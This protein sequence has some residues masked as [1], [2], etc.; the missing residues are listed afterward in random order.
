MSLSRLKMPSINASI[1]INE[2]STSISNAIN[3]E[4]NIASPIIPEQFP[5]TVFTSV[6]LLF[7]I[8][9]TIFA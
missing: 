5:I 8:W 9:F 7:V 2:Y 1:R 6:L 3:E 4:A